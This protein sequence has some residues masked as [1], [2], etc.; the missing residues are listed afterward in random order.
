MKDVHATLASSLESFRA[1]LFD[2]LRIPS[3][4]ARS[5]HDEDTRKAGAWVVERMRTAG[6]TAELLETDGHPVALGEW[7]GAGPDAP[8]LLI[9]GHYDVQPAEPLE[10]WTS[11][12]FEPEVRD[13]RIYARGAADD[14]GQLFLH[15]AALHILLETRG[16]LPVNV[17][18]LAEGEEEVGSPNLLPFVER[19]QERLAADAVV[20]S[21]SA[22][23]AEGLPSL[24]FSLRGLAY[25]EIRVQGARSDLHSGAYGGAVPNPA[26]ALARI[27]STLHDETGRITLPGFYDDVIAWDEETR[28]GVA[29]LPFD[30]EA[31]RE[32]TGAPGLSGEAGFGTLERLWVRPTCE[33]NG[34]LSG[35]TGQ[36]AKTVLPAQ[37]MAK[38]SFRLVP[39]QDP[40]RVIAQLRNHV[41][42]VTPTGVTVEVVELHGGR[43]WRARP[44]GVFFEAAR[45]AL[46]E[47]FGVPPVLTGEGGSIPIVTEFERILG[48]GAILL[49]FA[50]PGANMHAPDEW[51]PENH[52]ERGIETLLAFYS[53][54]DAS[55]PASSAPAVSPSPSGTDANR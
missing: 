36:G 51:F 54:L 26:M 6:L 23:F 24:L 25:A 11:P 55:F 39:D 15:L 7:R 41:A 12:P 33:V 18:V 4:S 32:G 3:V 46:E 19:W 50:L 34:L 21:D 35:Y 10:L 52:V 8:T 30:E 17:V 43:P 2:F 42:Q 16:S 48:A 37:A 38:V 22:M 5:E 20:I 28:A 31:F 44:G 53:R 1:E 27:L 49:G 47:A 13:G 40:A 9:Y 29:A 14:K 45:S